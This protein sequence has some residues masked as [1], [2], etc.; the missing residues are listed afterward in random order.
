MP[1][2]KVLCLKDKVKICEDSQKPG[3]SKEKCIIDYDIKRNTLN[4]LLQNKEKFLKFND[5]HSLNSKQKNCS[6][7]KNFEMEV[8]LKLSEWIKI[9]NSKGYPVSGEDIKTRALC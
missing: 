2:N 1:K 5:S 9:R 6:K 3:F 4:K 8:E 7:G